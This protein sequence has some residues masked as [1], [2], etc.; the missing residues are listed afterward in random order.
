MSDEEKVV[1]LTEVTVEDLTKVRDR[2][3]QKL[4]A[5]NKG[6]ASF[7]PSVVMSTRLDTFLDLF[8]QREQRIQFEYAFEI[9]MGEVLNDMLGQLRQAMLTQGVNQAVAAN[10][11]LVI[12][13]RG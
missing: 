12:P 3:Q 1:D 7:D 6:G 11:K 4:E 13:G 5:L 9:R 2:N 10:P 8:L